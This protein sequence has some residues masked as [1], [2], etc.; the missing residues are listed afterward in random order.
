MDVVGIIP[1]MLGFHPAESVVL[2]GLDGPQRR[3]CLTMRADLPQP[4]DSAAALSAAL[5]DRL[6]RTGAASAVGAVFASA[7]PSVRTGPGGES[8]NRARDLPYA[9]F[10][11]QLTRDLEAAGTPFLNVFLVSGQRIWSYGCRDPRCCPAE[12]TPVPESL[13]PA[14][15]RLRAEM[16]GR[17]RRV[18]SSRDELVDS[19]APPSAERRQALE[20]VFAAVSDD[21]LAR[22]TAVGVE[23]VRQ[24]T[25]SVARRLHAQYVRGDTTLAAGDAARLSL[26]LADVLARDDVLQWGGG[27]D[28]AALTALLLDV[29]GHALPPDDGPV[30]VALAWTAYQ[31]GN[32]A[33]AQCALDR[34]LASDPESTLGQLLQHALEMALPPD[35]LA[36]ARRDG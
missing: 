6:R 21:L 15:A 13:T 34:A 20:P 22:L 4:S 23:A 36:G 8:G 29:A 24:E 19:V 16:V 12:G 30:C 9:S 5:A 17:G 1:V 14:A 11:A 35:R 26:G 27:A 25:V 7:P 28:S 3:A 33:L 2:L 32:G 31:D 10:A 18:L